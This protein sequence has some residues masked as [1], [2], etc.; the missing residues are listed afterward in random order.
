M[1]KNQKKRKIRYGRIFDLINLLLFPILSILFV[2][3]IRKYSDKYYLYAI[4]IFVFLF[5]LTLLLFRIKNHVVEIIRRIFL[6]GLVVVLLAANIYTNDLSSGYQ[7]FAG[8]MDNSETTITYDVLTLKESTNGLSHVEDL[9]GYVV[10][11]PSNGSVEATDK[12]KAQLATK[13]SDFGSLAYDNYMTMYSDYT[14][15]FVD[16]IVIDQSQKGNLP[17]EYKNLYEISNVVD[18]YS[19]TIKNQIKGNDID[20]TKEVFTVLVSASDQTVAPTSHSLSDTNMLL[21]I[22]P[23][24]N[25]IQTISIPRDSFV[26]NP[27][28]DNVSDKL[29][30]TGNDGVDNTKLAVEETFNIKIDFYVKVSFVSLIEIVDT[31]GGIPVNVLQPIVEQDEYRSFAEEDLIYLEAGQQ[32]LSG[33]QALAYARHRHSY[34]NQDLGRNQA[35]IE[36]MK[37]LVKRV[38]SP[39][40]ITKVDDVMKLMSNYV[41]MNFSESQL[42]SLVKQQVDNMPSWQFKSLSLDKGEQGS[43][44]TASMPGLYSSIYYLSK[45]DIE[46]ANAIYNLMKERQELTDFHFDL[47][48]MYNGY[49]TY[50]ESDDI[51]LVP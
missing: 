35:Q 47:D 38:L 28:Y 21:I 25:V 50:E 42:T 9:D 5:I 17:E 16:A 10:G 31:L 32:T 7:A 6:A 13:I 8:S 27:A 48:D 4:G 12:A 40:G 43:D 20:I 26:P 30:H 14:K 45:S 36:V 1:K 19:F 49:S 29:T 22:D 46:K 11:F 3:F 39:E 18:T 23:I 41:I 33:K 44:V 2:L 51:Q 15:E 34:E 24:T 37:G